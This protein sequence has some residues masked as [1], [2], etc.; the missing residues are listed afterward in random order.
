MITEPGTYRVD[1]AGERGLVR[2]RPFV[3]G[4]HRLQLQTVAD[5]LAYFRAVRSSGEIDRKDRHARFYGDT[6]GAE[7]DARGG[8]LDASGDFSKFLSH[9]TYTRMM[10]P[11]QM[12]LCA[13]A[14]MAARDEA[15]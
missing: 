1:V 10:S 8:W 7:V 6:S 5:L 15:R 14:M 3:V 13:W 9:L 2:S 4:E 11:Q 12:P